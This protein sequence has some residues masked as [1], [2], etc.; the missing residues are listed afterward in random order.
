MN[1]IALFSSGPRS[2]GGRRMLVLL[3]SDTLTLL[4]VMLAAFAAREA[5]GGTVAPSTHVPLLFFLF[6]APCSNY[7]MGLYDSPPPAPP[8]ELRS[9]AFSTSL[10]Y[11]GIA[12]FLVM[13]RGEQP[14]RLV[15]AGAWLVSLPLVPL[16]RWQVRR[17]FADRLWWGT[18]AVLFGC[19]EV[20]ARLGSYLISHKELGIK[21]EVRVTGLPAPLD[22]GD[23][24]PREDSE[25]SGDLPLLRSEQQV[26][27]FAD[28]CPYA[29]AVV[30]VS[31]KDKR[32]R[33]I[34]IAARLFS[35][36]LLVPESFE[37]L[38]FWVRPV[39]IGRICCLRVRQ[40]LL[41]AR[42]LFLKR[43]MDLILSVAG[44]VLIL[45]LCL[46]IGVCIRL[47]S[48]GPVFFRHDRIGRGGRVIRIL[49][50]RT[51]VNDAQEAL[52]RH[53]AANPDLR[54]E[55]EADQ[56]LRN[57]P[58]ITRVGAVLR[59]TSLDELPQLWNVIRG[60]MSLVG[61]RPIVQSE[62]ERYGA[63][64]TA[65]SRVRP[66]ITGLWQVSGRNDLSYDTRVRI[67]RYYINNWSTCL[68]LVILAKTVPVVF[69]KKGAD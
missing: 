61:P 33:E 63:A 62:V 23:T 5:L 47:E 28:R 43:S 68:D 32:H 41:D 56:K 31:E 42:R 2:R 54:R 35:S 21:P 3:A 51:M 36:V 8:E 15:F 53:L 55:W 48:P 24:C 37:D 50:F 29:C 20:L 67:D 11:L 66:G 10:A 27:A 34:E 6:I 38:P 25:V 26:I 69:G 64:F 58:R 40:N 14:S 4:G 1:D 44:A 9:L 39:E 7:F 49:K 59:R 65:Y 46:I 57:D 30:V 22:A 17:M 60:E 19:G 18:P 13:G 12:I 16:A 45:P 52:A